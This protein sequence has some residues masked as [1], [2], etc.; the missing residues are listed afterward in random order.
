M[1]RMQEVRHPD[2]VDVREARSRGVPLSPAAVE[3]AA[4]CPVCSGSVP[5]NPTASPTTN[6]EAGLGGPGPD[7][8]ALFASLE[9]ALRQDDGILGRLRSR[10]T[11]E[12]VLLVAGWCFLIVAGIAVAAPRA[13]RGPVPT[14]HVLL[15][16][17][18]L[19]TLLAVALRFGLRP[20]NAH[21]R[22]LGVLLAGLGAA[23]L[24]PVVCAF[25]PSAVSTGI[26]EGVSSL[27]AA[28]RCFATGVLSGAAVIAALFALDRGEHRSPTVALLA[29]AAGGLVAN[30]ALELHCAVTAPAHLLLGHASVSLALAVAYVALR[31]A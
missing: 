10:P 25:L 21:R 28:S 30:A 27:H 7:Q 22:V 17:T 3:H 1:T 11:T 8:A 6:T 18:V 15:V 23:L 24:A 31:R 9:E 16:V 13:A 26:P 4:R 19:S 5:A 29:A 20:C 12:R 14:E 2:C